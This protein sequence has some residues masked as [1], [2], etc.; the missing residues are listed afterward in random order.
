MHYN[1]MLRQGKFGSVEVKD[2]KGNILS[3]KD[4]RKI[5]DMAF[6]IFV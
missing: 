5:S 1:E 3:H 2:H 4:V 6:V